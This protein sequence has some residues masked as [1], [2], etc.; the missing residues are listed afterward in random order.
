MNSMPFAGQYTVNM[1][2]Q[3]HWAY[4]EY[5]ERLTTMLNRC[6]EV[7]RDHVFQGRCQTPDEW[8]M[9]WKAYGQAFFTKEYLAMYCSNLIPAAEDFITQVEAWQQ[10]LHDKLN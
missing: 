7:I 2:D 9:L 3:E 5:C 4:M 10:E 8:E 6:V 1:N